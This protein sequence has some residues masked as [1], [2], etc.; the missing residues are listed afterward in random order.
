[1][2]PFD[3]PK[4]GI[5]WEH[6]YS[7]V[8]F[9]W[10]GILRWIW[11]PT[12]GCH[13]RPVQTPQDSTRTSHITRGL[14]WDVFSKHLRARGS[15]TVPMTFQTDLIQS[16]KANLNEGGSTGTDRGVP[17]NDCTRVLNPGTHS[18]FPYCLHRLDFHFAI[19]FSSVW[20]VV[21]TWIDPRAF[22]C[23]LK[24]SQASP[25]LI[26][27]VR[28]ESWGVWTGNMWPTRGGTPN[29]P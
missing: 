27:E 11:C 21:G 25:L 18:Q 6:I 4:T 24:T 5:S 3:R 26:W 13:M 14:T 12:S 22:K 15:T 1:M 9:F 29:P 20:C 28:M 16:Q 19:G 8:F 7:F 23:L 2:L 10:Y 17:Q